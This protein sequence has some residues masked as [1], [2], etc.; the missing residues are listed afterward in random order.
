MCAVMYIFDFMNFVIHNKVHKFQASNKVQKVQLHNYEINHVSLH[1]FINAGGSF[2][3]ERH[4][5][6]SY[7]RMAYHQVRPLV[8]N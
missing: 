6:D 1:Y 7:G 4:T 3:Q 2:A 8:V 5:G